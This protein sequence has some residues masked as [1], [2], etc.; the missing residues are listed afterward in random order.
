MGLQDVED[1]SYST[2]A[3]VSFNHAFPRSRPI[4]V[5]YAG[6]APLYDWEAQ[7][8]KKTRFATL[9]LWNVGNHIARVTSAGPHPTFLHR[10]HAIV[11]WAAG[12]WRLAGMWTSGRD[13]CCA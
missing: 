7:N 6:Q 10:P 8:A 5:H 9:K 12:W 3:A 13:Q 11:T 1:R 2:A 4:A